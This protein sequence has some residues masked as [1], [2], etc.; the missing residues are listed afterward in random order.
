MLTLLLFDMLVFAV[1]MQVAGATGTIYIKVDGS[2]DPS[3]A[4]IHRDGDS[5]TFIGNMYDSIVIQKNNIIIDG[6]G[7]TVQGIGNGT[8]IKLDRRSNVTIKNVEINAFDSGIG[9]YSSS[10]NSISGNNIKNN[11]YG[12]FFTNS[13]GNSISGNNI[14]GGSGAIELIYSSSNSISENNVTN[15]GLGVRLYY[16]L[17]NIIVG[18]NLANNWVGIRLDKS[19]NNNVLGNNIT[20]HMDHGI[21]LSESSNNSIIRNNLSKIAYASI[22]LEWASNNI[23]YYNSFK[24]NT[25]QVI[26]KAGYANSWDNGY[27]GNYW[28]D[29]KGFDVFSG[30]YQNI[31]GSDGIGDLPYII[32]A[33]NQDRYPLI[34]PLSHLRGDLNGDL[35]VDGKDIAVVAKAFGSYPG[36]PRWNPR[37]DIN[38]DNVIEGMDIA[39]AAKNFGK[40]WT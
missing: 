23:I 6:A 2:V 38:Q 39:I 32:D 26:I 8:G 10:N 27:E 5:Y 33:N 18:N 1:S 3:T 13:S 9:L 30:P 11:S 4:P 21:F 7:Y 36:Q 37:A 28:S 17:D 40:E 24:N 31:T 19:S 15:N 20:R 34:Y 35:E 16:S 14:T 25:L 22:W 12:V 29:Y